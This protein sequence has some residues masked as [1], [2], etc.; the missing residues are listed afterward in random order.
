[1]TLLKPAVNQT[2]YP[3]AVVHGFPGGGKTYTA[4]SLALALCVRPGRA[5]GRQDTELRGPHG[6]HEGGR[7]AVLRL[8][9]STPSATSAW[10]GRVSPFA[11][12]TVCW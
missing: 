4:A 10:A 12:S 2:A 9:S 7:G 3:K 11:R 6:V 5:A 1:M 8:P